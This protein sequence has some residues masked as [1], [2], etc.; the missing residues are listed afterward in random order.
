MT[1]NL[2]PRLIEVEELEKVSDSAELVIIDLSRDKTYAGGHIRGARHLDYNH[3]VRAEK[4]VMG[5]LPTAEQFSHALSSVGITAT[6]HIV[7]YDD[8]GGGKAA[9]LLWTLECFGHRHYSLLN[10]GLHAWA[11]EGHPLTTETSPFE[12]GDY[13][14]N[15]I[16]GCEAVVNGDY[17]LN[18]L[19]DTDIAL[20]DARSPQEFS[21]EKRYAE[22]AGHIPGAVNIEWTAFMD[23]GRNL[24]LKPEAEL[25]RM[26]E[27]KGFTTDKTVVA[28]CQTHHR[29]A[30][31]WFVLNY[32][33]YR[34]RGY[35]GSWSD[36][37][38]RED[39]PIEV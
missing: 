35:E 6:N 31:T 25:R 28:C 36:W 30:H 14:L 38:N 3:I 15:A 10:G 32:M 22:R 9:R 13:Q 21:G 24:R 8:E 19:N 11:N 20:L 29:S 4:P 23:Q 33:G 26:L 27:D 37:G 17:I 12:P 39:T 1:H 2:L 7:A 34:A 16:E 5:L 18:H